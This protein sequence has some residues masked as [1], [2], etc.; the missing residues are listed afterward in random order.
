MAG[1]GSLQGLER[2]CFVCRK[3]SLF[4]LVSLCDIFRRD[5]FEFD[6]VDRCGVVGVRRMVSSDTSDL[7]SGHL[8]LGPE[9]SI[10]G[11]SR[12]YPI[13]HL[14]VSA[15]RRQDH[16]LHLLVAGVRVFAQLEPPRLRTAEDSRAVLC[17]PQR[18]INF[19][20]VHKKYW[21]CF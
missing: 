17:I 3:S 2:C 20:L 11:S 4:E 10:F 8:Q 18:K 21:R 12:Q 15:H 5:E 14:V 1:P 9:S 16:Y 6:H 19:I 7:S 13:N